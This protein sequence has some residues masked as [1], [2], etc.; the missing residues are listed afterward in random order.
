MGLYVIAKNKKAL[1]NFSVLETYTAGLVLRGYEV[2]AIREGK[3]SFEGSYINGQ[4]G[5]LFVENLYIGRYS[6]QSRDISEADEKRS[7]ALLLNK[8]EIA[9]VSRAISE[10]GK[11][12][13]PLA[14][15]LKNGNIKLEFAVAKG[16]KEWEKKVVAKDRQIQRDLERESKEIMSR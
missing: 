11:T 15:V 13:V 14:L 3:V 9:E 7:R 5:R 2:K 8:N 4:D 10:K 1:H 12:A 6:K 16:K